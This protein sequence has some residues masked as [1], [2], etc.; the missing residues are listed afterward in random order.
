MKEFHENI[1][2]AFSGKEV[3]RCVDYRAAL[4]KVSHLM[5]GKLPDDFQVILDT[6]AEIQNLLYAY[7]EKRTPRTVL[8]LHNLTFWHAVMLR[9]I[10]GT[11]MKHITM[12]KLYGKYFHGIISHSPLQYRLLSGATMNAEDEER[13][14]NTIKR[15]TNTTFSKHPDHVIGNAIIQF[16]VEKHTHSDDGEAV[17]SQLK[18]ISEL[19]KIMDKLPNSF[20][21]FKITE[22]YSS[23]W[24]AHL[25]QISD[26]LLCGEGVWWSQD[27]NGITFKDSYNEAEHLPEGPAL[28]HFRSWTLEKEAEYIRS[29]WKACLDKDVIIPIHNEIKQHVSEGNCA[30]QLSG[31]NVSGGSLGELEGNDCSL[32]DS[33]EDTH[34]KKDDENV[35]E[36]HE[37]DSD[38]ETEQNNCASAN[39]DTPNISSSASRLDETPT[40]MITN[41]VRIGGEQSES[42]EQE[43]TVTPT[44]QKKEN[45]FKG[46]LIPPPKL[47]SAPKRAQLLP[48]QKSL[49]EPEL[50]KPITKL[51]KVVFVV[52]VEIPEVKSL[53][54]LRSRMKTNPQ[55]STE[56]EYLDLLAIIQTKVSNALGK[57]KQDLKTWEKGFLESNKYL[58]TTDYM[59]KDDTAAK[60]LQQIKYGSKLIKEWKIDI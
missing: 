21:P 47:T 30:K 45:Y 32:D 60:F 44:Q 24:Q 59:S 3:K 53:D 34:E 37:A 33:E 35:L 11:K 48:L 56:K 41:S 52:L 4:L 57:A 43:V 55:K 8:R 5:K 31:S 22:A 29:C 23:A 54:I 10:L 58:P 27:E 49:I 25:E 16:Q 6:L 50:W 15:I 40:I 38:D 19:F 28:H 51:G 9:V 39:S 13:V 2:L 1:N 26:F 7:D 18:E 36:V 42:N 17:Q 14:F 12:R 46:S 20:F